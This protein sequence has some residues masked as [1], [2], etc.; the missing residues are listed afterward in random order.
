MATYILLLNLTSEGRA[1]AFRDPDYLL[2]VENGISIPGVQTLGVYAVLGPYDY[3]T[4][5]SAPNNEAIAR[6]SLELGVKASVQA[7]T[8]PVIPASSLEDEL[9][10]SEAEVGLEAQAP[11]PPSLL[12][13]TAETERFQT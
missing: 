12:V 13:G 7:T 1:K 9:L 10:V 11:S 8:L 2:G 5:V 6:F 4:L 3:V